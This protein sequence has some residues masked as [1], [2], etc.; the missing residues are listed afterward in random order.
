MLTNLE[1]QHTIMMV[2]EQVFPPKYELFEI[3][4]KHEYSVSLTKKIDK[5]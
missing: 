4:S 1:T 2:F 3:V 5:E